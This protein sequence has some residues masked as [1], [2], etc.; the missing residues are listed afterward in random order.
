VTVV[1]PELVKQT[2]DTEATMRAPWLEA[3]L[4]FVDRDFDRAIE[5]YEATGSATDAPIVRLRAAAAMVEQG[6][7]AEADAYLDQALAFHRSV[8]AKH[9]IAQGEALL[10]AT[11]CV[12]GLEPLTQVSRCARGSGV[13]PR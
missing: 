2:W 8:G 4:A 3:A 6:R 7:R 12:S 1:G 5:I 9:F 13:P 11:A 10:A